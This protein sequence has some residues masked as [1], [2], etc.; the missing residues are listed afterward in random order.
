MKIDLKKTLSFT[1]CY[2][3]NYVIDFYQMAE[4]KATAVKN[5]VA[6]FNFLYDLLLIVTLLNVII[7][8]IVLENCQTDPATW[9]T[10]QKMKLV[11]MKI[12]HSEYLL[13]LCSLS[14]FFFYQLSIWSTH[15]LRILLVFCSK[16]HLYQLLFRFDSNL[17]SIFHRILLLSVCILQGFCFIL[18]NYW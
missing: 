14:K 16:L 13:M 6:I 2:F 17:Y 7:V 9:Y 8:K 1:G 5:Y 11:F 4:M 15:D 12:S 18:W 3:N 10:V